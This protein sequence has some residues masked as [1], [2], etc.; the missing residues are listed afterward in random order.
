MGSIEDRALTGEILCRLPVNLEPRK[1]LIHKMLEQSDLVVELGGNC[2]EYVNAE[3][4]LKYV[5]PGVELSIPVTLY[6][7]PGATLSSPP[8]F[9]AKVQIK[10]RNLSRNTSSTLSHGWSPISGS[11]YMLG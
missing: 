7:L 10:M 6:E 4:S 1:N 3:K 9:P 11:P 5:R 2:C 8:I